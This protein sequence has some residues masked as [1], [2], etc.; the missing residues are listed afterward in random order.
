MATFT[1][2][3]EVAAEPG[4]YRRIDATVD[5]GA[6]YSWAPRARL[7][8]LGVKPHARRKFMFADGSVA[9]LDIGR[10][11]VRINGQEELTLVVFGEEDSPAI[12]GTYTLEA[13]NLGADPA[14]RRLEP[15]PP[16]PMLF[17]SSWTAMDSSNPNVF[18]A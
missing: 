11:W 14:N 18:L 2:R 5:T 15:L 17:Y 16:L 9:E 7:E 1:Q 10:V 13:F 3:I 4:S 12:I 6:F 8:R